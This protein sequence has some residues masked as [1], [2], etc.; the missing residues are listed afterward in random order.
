M[1]DLSSLIRLH[2]Y[3]L[4]EKQRVLAELYGQQKVLEDQK[5][6]LQDKVKAEQKVIEEQGGEVHYTLAGFIQ[7]VKQETLKI[8][9]QIEMI[10]QDV[11]V[12]KEALMDVF[13]ELK[14][15]EMTQAERDR[16]ELK[17]QKARETMELDEIALDVFRRKTD[18]T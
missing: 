10:D 9:Y 6:A 11:V 8:E 7:S 17:Q 12:A 3:D 16:V 15:Y 1:A 18:E 5:Q 13:A 4:D 14:K 2:Q